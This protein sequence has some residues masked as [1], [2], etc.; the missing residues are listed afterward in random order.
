[1]MVIFKLAKGL[2]KAGTMYF[3]THIATYIL[4]TNTPVCE[5]GQV[6]FSWTQA[7]GSTQ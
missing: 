6:L 2:Y 3:P 7:K 4:S 1:M 5:N